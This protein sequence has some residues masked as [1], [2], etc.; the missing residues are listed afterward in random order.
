MLR[1]VPDRHMVRF[2][3]NILSNRSFKTKTSDG[4]TSRHRHLQNGV[5]QGSTLAPPPPLQHLHQRLSI[6]NIKPVFI[7]WRPGSAVLQQVMVK[8]GGDTLGTCRPWLSIT[9]HG[10]SSL[11]W[12]DHGYSFSF[13]Q[14]GSQKTHELEIKRHSS[15]LHL[16]PNLPGCEA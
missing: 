16:L 10:D 3:V 9:K 12:Q 7:C 5:L 14:Q 1:S 8:C 6:N 13:E 2:L 11:T 15:H 4:Q